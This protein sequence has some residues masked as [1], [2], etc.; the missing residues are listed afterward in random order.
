MS[1]CTSLP[2]PMMK[3]DA[4]TSATRMPTTVDADT[5]TVDLETTEGESNAFALRGLE[6]TGALPKFDVGGVSVTEGGVYDAIRLILASAN[7]GITVDGGLEASKRNGSRT[8]V[9]L[10]GDI[11]DVLTKMSD[12]FG[13]YWSYSSGVVKI[14]FEQQFVLDL[15]PALSDDGMAGMVNTMKY[16]GAKDTYLDRLSRTVAFKADKNAANQITAY[17]ADVRKHRALIVYETHIYQVNLN[18]TNTQGI[19]WSAMSHSNLVGMASSHVADGNSLVSGTPS[20][21]PLGQ[22]I[23]GTATGIGMVASFNHFSFDMLVNFLQ[24]QGTVKTVSRPRLAL[25]SGSKA[26]F[27]VGQATSYVSKVGTNYSSSVNQVTTETSELR[28]GLDM[29][30][31]GDYYEGTVFTSINLSLSDLLTMTSFTA[32]GTNLTLPTTQDRVLKT[33]IRARPGDTFLLG[34]ITINSN[35]MTNQRGISTNGTADIT[36][37]S[38]LVIAI[39][40]RII[41]FTAPTTPTRPA[42]TVLHPTDHNVDSAKVFASELGEPNKLGES[43]PPIESKATVAAPPAPAATAPVPAVVPPSKAPVGRVPRAWAPVAAVPTHSISA[44]IPSL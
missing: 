14:R 13:F 6:P 10:S 37:R 40:P 4:P 27:R 12:L 28:T 38:E 16:L 11:T 22:Q 35:S 15:P 39:Q 5:D 21:S 30:I 29:S 7:I 31:Y 17:L 2:R 33:T 25:I 36:G 19:Q 24:T 44:R 1:A 43:A 26:N 32:L 42:V 20:L 41:R 9:K 3:P 23:T 8:V 18:D 34:G